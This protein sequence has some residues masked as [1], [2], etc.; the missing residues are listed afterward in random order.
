M[1]IK[2]Y[3]SELNKQFRTRI[4][5]EHNYRPALQQMIMSILADMVVTNEP[6]RIYCG[7]LDYMISR[8]SD[9]IPVT[10][11]EAKDIDDSDLDGRKQNK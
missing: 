1:N 11:V 5:R 7:A 10:F 2:Y 3:I 6:A 9:N 4:A 8:K